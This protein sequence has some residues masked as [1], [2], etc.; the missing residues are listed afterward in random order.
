M[1][2]S[3]CLTKLLEGTMKS[4]C[5]LLVALLAGAVSVFCVTSPARAQYAGNGTPLYL[6]LSGNTLAGSGFEPS[7][8]GT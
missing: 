5:I 2:A 4:R 7:P 3:W 1:V 6:D 8:N